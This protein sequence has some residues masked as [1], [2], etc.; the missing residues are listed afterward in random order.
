[1]I[2]ADQ[3]VAD[4]LTAMNQLVQAPTELPQQYRAFTAEV[5]RTADQASRAQARAQRMQSQW[6]QYITTWEQELAQVGTPE[7]RATAAER[8]KAVRRNFERIRREVN[9]VQAAYRPFIEQLQ[10]IQTALALDL[11]PAGLQAA[12]PAIDP[13]RQTGSQLMRQIAEVVTE[14]DNVL[15]QRAA[16][17]APGEPVAGSQ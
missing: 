8:R 17:P 3:Q 13:A 1:L 11:T 7:L 2:R 16:L 4:T 6:Q 14:I 5:S 9:D 15:M 12:R 10:D